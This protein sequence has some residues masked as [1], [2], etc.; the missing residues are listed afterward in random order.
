MDWGLITVVLAI[1][2]LGAHLALDGLRLVKN[3]RRLR[4]TK[5]ES[6]DSW[7]CERCRAIEGGLADLKHEAAWTVA[8]VIVLTGHIILDFVQKGA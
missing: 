2:F 1:A 3:V 8:A 5:Y 7:R 4:H 6:L